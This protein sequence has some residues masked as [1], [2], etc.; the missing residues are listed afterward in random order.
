MTEANLS[1]APGRRALGV[2]V[3]G[4]YADGAARPGSDI[5]IQIVTENAATP[6]RGLPDRLREEWAKR[7]TGI[8]LDIISLTYVPPDPGLLIRLHPEAIRVFSPYP[9]MAGALSHVPPQ[10]SRPVARMTPVGRLLRAM[11]VGALEMFL[12]LGDM[13]DR[14]GL[15]PTQGKR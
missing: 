12:R 11:C 2:L 8:D 3:F 15:A 9:G 5:D 6:G 10:T 1:T 13:L 14:K 7:G 4:S